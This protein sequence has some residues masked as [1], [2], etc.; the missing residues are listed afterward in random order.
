[1]PGHG[2]PVDHDARLLAC[3]GE[4]LGIEGRSIRLHGRYLH[5]L[6]PNVLDHSQLILDGQVGADHAPSDRLSDLLGRFVRAG[7]KGR[8]G[9]A[10]Q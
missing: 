8:Q 4:F 9:R 6:E 7:R 1:M 2:D 3:P 10:A 5:A